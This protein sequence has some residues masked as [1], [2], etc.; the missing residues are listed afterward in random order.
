MRRYAQEQ[1]KTGMDRGANTDMRRWGSGVEP[2]KRKFNLKA[3]EISVGVGEAQD[4]R[5]PASE[6]ITLTQMKGHD[7][8]GLL[9]SGGLQDTGRGDRMLHENGMG[10]GVLHE[11]GMG[12]GVTK[13]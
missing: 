11:N 9:A 12:D 6:E 1:N 2:E 3:N 5:Q 13:K 4:P 8:E 10:E 7:G